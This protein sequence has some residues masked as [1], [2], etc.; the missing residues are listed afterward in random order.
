MHDDAKEK[1]KAEIL[2]Q[3]FTKQ[4][5]L[6]ETNANLPSNMPN[7]L[8]HIDRVSIL[9]TEVEFTLRVLKTGKA[10]CPDSVNNIILKELAQ[11]LS[12]PMSDLFNYSL[13]SGK[14]PASWK[15]ANVTHI[16]KKD[17]PSDDTN[18]RPISLLSTIGKALE[19]II[20]K[21]LYN[22]FHENHVITTLQ[23]GFVPGDSTV[24]QLADL[25][26]TFC[27]A[28]DEGKEVRAIFC[29]ISKAFDRVWHKGLSFKLKA[30]GVS[31]SLLN[32]FCDYLN[33]RRQRV[34]LPGGNSEWSDNKAG[35][36]RGSILGPLLFLLYINDIVED[37]H[38]SIRL[39]ADDTSHYII[40]DNPTEAANQLN[41]DLEKINQ[42]AKKWLVT[43]NPTKSESTI[44]SRKRIKPPHPPVLMDYIQIKE[45]T[46]HKHLGL[47]FSN[48]CTWHNHLEHIKTR[49][50]LVSI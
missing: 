41:S 8:Y 36:P 42:W 25:Y 13:A 11:P 18:Y 40:V 24:N 28:L 33:D 38:S 47:I 44:L 2:N 15:Q 35:V 46:S 21:Y 32:W 9:P 37:I 34:V 43:F 1:E 23:S 22:Y 27:K 5:V 10:A 14:V 6:D 16:F 17:N 45:V 20:H 7:S 50:G 30:A 26:N 19:K 4:T 3:H 31:G 29:D 48:D 12:S 49:H 39:F